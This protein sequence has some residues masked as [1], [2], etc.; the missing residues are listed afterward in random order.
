MIDLTRAKVNKRV[1]KN[2]FKAGL[3]AVD[4]ITWLY[5]ISPETADFRRGD[6][7]T[8]I[9][10]FAVT[11]KGG[12][13]NKKELAAIQKAIPYPIL[14]IAGGKSYFTVEG[15]QFE[16][17]KAFLKGDVLN[18]EK[19]SCILTDLYEDIAAEFVPLT[20]RT[21]ESIAEL[22]VRYRS[23]TALDREIASLQ[24]QVDGEKQPNKRIKQNERL[25]ELK[26]AKEALQ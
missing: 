26:A 11:F 2:R 15:E 25:K 12:A 3:A 9:Q 24:R 18:I 22:A 8:E 19:R 4:T 5:K 20:R 13:V 10:I 17:G 14:F 6:A 1:P 7:V 16:S 23:I 21:G